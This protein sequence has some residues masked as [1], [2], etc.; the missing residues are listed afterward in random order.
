MQIV[1]IGA[2]KDQQSEIARQARFEDKLPLDQIKYV[3]GFSTSFRGTRCVCAATVID[4]KTM[5]TVEKK[6]LVTKAPMNYLPG[7][8][9]SR[10]GPVICQLYYDLEFEPDVILVSGHGLAHPVACGLATFVGVE[11]GKPTFGAAKNLVFGEEKDDLIVFDEQVI[12][13]IVKTH[14]YANPLYVSPGNLI[15]VETAAK[16][17]EKCIVPPHT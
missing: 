6:F 7:F 16:I 12:G 2:L 10:E 14:E 4:F 5:K 13:R 8:E 11:L 9:A 15:S 3:A 1:N 17:V